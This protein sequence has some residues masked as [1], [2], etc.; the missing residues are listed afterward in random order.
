VTAAN[1]NR[2]GVPWPPVPA[3]SSGA[4]ETFSFLTDNFTTRKIAWIFE[5]EDAITI[6]QLGFAFASRTGTPPTYR[7]SLQGVDASGNP[8]GTVVG[9]GS[10]ASQTFT[11]P[12]DNTWNTTFRWIALANSFTVTRGTKYAIVVEYSSGTADASNGI[13]V[14]NGHTNIGARSGFP[15]ANQYGGASWSHR[16]IYPV[17]GYRDASR[18]YGMPVASFFSTTFSSDTNQASGGDERGIQFSLK[19]GWGDTYKMRGFE[20]IGNMSATGKT[21][22]GTLYSGTSALQDTA[23]F[24]SDHAQGSGN[25]MTFR[26]MFQDATLDDLD[27]GTQYIIALKPNETASSLGVYGVVVQDAQD[28][29]CFGFGLDAQW[30]YRADGGA[31]QTDITTR[32]PLI[33]PILDDITEP[34]GGGGGG[35][36]ILRRG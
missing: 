12:A 5:P 13:V 36:I 28:R 11:P 30:V 1:Y 15:I 27:F 18:S 2:F 34:A 6:T 10:P 24:D 29:E 16:N 20:A 25:Y 8:D 22:T 26:F 14:N 23:A 17:Y 7:I 19:S 31:W 21:V 32:V 33:W 35:T 3:V 9:G 4:F